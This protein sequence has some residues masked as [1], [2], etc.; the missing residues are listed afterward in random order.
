MHFG[1]LRVKSGLLVP[2]SLLWAYQFS[3]KSPN[4]AAEVCPFG[5]KVPIVPQQ[6]RKR[7]FSAGL[8]SLGS[9]EVLSE[10]SPRSPNKAA[11]V[12]PVNANIPI[13]P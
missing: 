12:W 6:G 7:P 1:H 13:V 3:P 5:A 2:T 10:F 4:S 9:E 11:A 8:S